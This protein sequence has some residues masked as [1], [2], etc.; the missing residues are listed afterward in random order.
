MLAKRIDALRRPQLNQL[1]MDRG[2]KRMEFYET[3]FR[4]SRQHIKNTCFGHAE[5]RSSSSD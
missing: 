1:A 3:E 2:L 4:V 5:E